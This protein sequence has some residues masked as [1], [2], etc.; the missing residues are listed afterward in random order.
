MQ[1]NRFLKE[2]S[3]DSSVK[4][5]KMSLYYSTCSLNPSWFFLSCLYLSLS[6]RAHINGLVRLLSTQH[7]GQMSGELVCR[8]LLSFRGE[9]KSTLKKCFYYYYFFFHFFFIL[10]RWVSPCDP[11]QKKKIWTQE[12]TQMAWFFFIILWTNK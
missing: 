2:Y 6:R 10:S 4:I 12:W 1:I 7:R 11:S 8:H 9:L 3:H 5:Y